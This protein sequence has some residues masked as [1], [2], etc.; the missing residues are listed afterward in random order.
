M[1]YDDDSGVTQEMLEM[2]FKDTMEKAHNGDAEAQYDLGEVFEEGR[3]C[4]WTVSK[5]LKNALKWYQ[6]AADN[7]NDD[8]QFQMG[9]CYRDGD[10]GV[11]KNPREAL[12]Y[13]E[14]WSSNPKSFEHDLGHA[15]CSEY[16]FEM[17]KIVADLDGNEEF[18]TPDSRNH[19]PR[20]LV[21]RSSK[22][23][24]YLT[25]QVIR[26]VDD[27]VLL[28]RSI[29]E[30]IQKISNFRVNVTPQI[31]A[32]DAVK[33]KHVRAYMGQI[34]RIEQE[35]KILKEQFLNLLNLR[36]FVEID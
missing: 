14:L 33:A 21:T 12:R 35:Q 24:P 1:T 13:F 23:A 28:K 20:D 29:L 18:F 30:D 26:A 27:H 17:R 16:L 36:V 22:D 8:A 6:M 10:L 32:G 11:S 34:A 15:E 2:D 3:E 31:L 19:V 7:G 5:D 4:G 9:I 25:E